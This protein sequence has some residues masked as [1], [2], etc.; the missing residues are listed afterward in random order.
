MIVDGVTPWR[1]F[2]RFA[3]AKWFRWHRTRDTTSS[4][5]KPYNA[6]R[7]TADEVTRWLARYKM[8]VMTVWTN[9]DAGVLVKIPK[10]Q[11]LPKKPA[12]VKR[13]P[14]T[15]SMMADW[16]HTHEGEEVWLIVNYTR[17][18]GY[19]GEWE[20]GPGRAGERA[21]VK[22]ARAMTESNDNDDVFKAVR[23]V[24]KRV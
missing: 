8:H 12:P 16:R 5:D 9:D 20:H 22:L 19:G 4:V 7:L 10:V 15:S 17:G 24:I 18:I 2:L 11:F 14:P 3:D 23:C 1:Y 21:A 6:T 13:P